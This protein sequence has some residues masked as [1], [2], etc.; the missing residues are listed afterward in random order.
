MIVINSIYFSIKLKFPQ[1][2]FKQAIKVLKI[3]KEKD[4]I[5]PKDTLIMSLSSK[6]GVGSLSGTAIAIYYGGLGTIFWIFISTFF[7]SIIS[8]IENSLAIIYREKGKSGPHYYIK[9][10]INKHFL[11]L[12]YAIL[13]LMSY[14]MLFSSIQNNTIT[15]LI[16]SVYSVNK[17]IIS[18]IITITTSIIIVKDIKRISHICNKIFSIMMLIFISTG[19]FTI[20]KNIQLLPYITKRII[21]EALKP[22]SINGGI[23]YSI[24]IAIQKAVFANE[25]GVGT[26]AIISAAAENSNYRTQANIGLLQTYFI[27]FIVLGITS[28]II[29]LADTNNIKIIN[30]IE[31][32]KLAFSYHLGTIG[33]IIIVLLVTLFS[34]STIITVY[35][36]GENAL[37]FLINSK[38]LA[39]LLKIVTIA[40][41]FTG[42]LIKATTIWILI[43]IS[44]AIL[45]IINMY[46]LYKLRKTIILKLK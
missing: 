30:G 40:F 33:E 18:A 23:I 28:L 3:K 4:S 39:P 2:R 38:K 25:S 20:L 29:A 45:T 15:T 31:L 44:L 26:N 43:D 17:V 11:S 8:Y 1:L 19:L 9:K 34:F 46:A 5:S 42:G 6:I 35:Y 36:Y 37:E 21:L 10:V 16:N 7:L 24:I 22:N 27:N 13:I 41:I 32:T 14:S 12:V